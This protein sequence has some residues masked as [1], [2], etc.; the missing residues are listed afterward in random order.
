[1][2][3]I[4]AFVLDLVMVRELGSRGATMGNVLATATGPLARVARAQRGFLRNIIAA[5]LIYGVAI[6]MML[7]DLGVSLYQAVCFRLW[8]V[9]QVRRSAYVRFDRHKLPYLNLLQKLNCFY[10]SYANGVF[11]YFVE[12]ASKTEKYWCP[13]Q[14]ATLPL[15]AHSR[16]DSFLKYGDGADISEQLARQRAELTREPR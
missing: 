1:M 7:C 3:P 13:I 4:K 12:V 5:P 8:G 14:E 10:C 16:Y 11:A 6:P 15:S 9:A 2:R